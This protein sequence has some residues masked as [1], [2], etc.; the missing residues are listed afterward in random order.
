MGSG[1]GKNVVQ[2][3]KGEYAGPDIRGDEGWKNPDGSPA[4]PRATQDD[5]AYIST[6]LAAA[7]FAGGG[8]TFAAATRVLAA[9][10]LTGV[11]RSGTEK[12]YYRIK[13]TA[14]G[15]IG[16]KLSVVPTGYEN[17]PRAHLSA[18]VS[19]LRGDNQAVVVGTPFNNVGPTGIDG[20]DP[21]TDV[22]TVTLPGPGTYVIELAPVG[23]GDPTSTGYTAYGSGGSYAISLTD[24][25]SILDNTPDPN[26]DVVTC[27]SPSYTLTT[28][29]C[30]G[31]TP[32][33]S[34]LYTL[35][36]GP[37]AAP[38][39]A[40][41]GM[42]SLSGYPSGGLFG[43]GVFQVVVTATEGGA[44]C[45]STVTVLPCKPIVISTRTP[46]KVDSA[47]GTCL[48]AALP[49]PSSVITAAS[50][51]AGALSLTARTTAKGAILTSPF[52]AG[53]YFV[54]VVY[55][56]GIKSS[57]SAGKFVLAINDVQPP[58]AT[59]KGS[60]IRE[61]GTG[62]ICA[63]SKG[64]ATSACLNVATT[65]TASIIS[66]T[67]NCGTT[68]LVRKYTCTPTTAGSCPTKATAASA[69]KICVNVSATGGR[70]DA[71]YAV[72]ITD[73]GGRATTLSIPI[74]GYHAS[75]KPANVQCYSA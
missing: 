51:G 19:V 60:I 45:T 15:P 31:A 12:H 53:S 43:P 59:I 14:G 46:V 22:N 21:E 70:V 9:T 65:G 73:K 67:D 47:A 30:S 48:G 75:K 25:N 26:P 18:Q 38:G 68:G 41:R 64:R 69:T 37:A 27:R 56:G 29:K 42:V 57:L 49:S 10:D 1:F 2:W 34:E 23:Y 50:L 62:A 54:D 5:I 39:S 66:L 33:L 4:T 3:S 71:T 7:D 44:T 6:V 16:L 55:P 58:S 8:S 24:G 40:P 36:A 63:V 72:T 17:R 32:A 13:T 11:L 28:G 61:D 52:K 74:A 35:S 20:N